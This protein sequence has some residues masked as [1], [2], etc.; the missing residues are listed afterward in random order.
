VQQKWLH[1]GTLSA[2]DQMISG[3]IGP[4]GESFYK[5]KEASETFGEMLSRSLVVR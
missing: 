5:N 3:M 2:L 4:Y 1:P